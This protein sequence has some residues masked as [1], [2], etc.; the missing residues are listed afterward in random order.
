MSAGTLYL[1]SALK[2]LRNY[3]ELG[4]KTFSQ[5]TETDFHFQPNES[6]NSIGVIIQH[7]AGN[8]L[9][10]WTDFMT[11]DG[12]KE[13]RNR[14]GEFE[15]QQMSKGQLLDFWEKGWN[16]CF[17]A[18]SALTEADLSKTIQIRTESL[19]VVDAINRQLAHY[20]SHVGQILLM[21]KI[22][23]G[24]N[25]QNLSIPKGHSAS[26]NKDVQEGVKRQP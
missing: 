2:R 24:S 1:E 11:S 13:W 10:R 23:K 20:P 14:D 6:C 18:I 22:I 4:D 8:M 21:G 5:L 16:C 9:S 7:M 25:W 26:Y 3:K 15:E 19:T 12:E 17:N